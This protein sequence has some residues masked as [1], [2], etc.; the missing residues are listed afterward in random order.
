[1]KNE[2][3]NTEETANSDL[4]AISGSTYVAE[5]RLCG[6]CK[7]FKLDAGANITG[8][9]C[10]KLMTVISSMYINYRKGD[11]SCFE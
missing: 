5:T 6:D 1:M 2:T 10:K 8:T 11:G 7:N 9:C 4:G 3:L